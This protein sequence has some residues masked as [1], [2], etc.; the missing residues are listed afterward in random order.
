VNKAIDNESTNEMM[1]KVDTKEVKTS[2]ETWL[3]FNTVDIEQI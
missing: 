1:K 2:A 3:A